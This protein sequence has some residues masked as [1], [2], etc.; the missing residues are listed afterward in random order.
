M[1]EIPA[2]PPAGK[3]VKWYYRT[4]SVLTA[5]VLFGPLAYPLLWKSPKYNLT[6]KIIL[7][8]IFTA[9]TVYMI[10]ATWHIYALL[11][12]TFRQAGLI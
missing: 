3:T 8:V 7:T 9:A 10:I 4:P 12:R 5:L 2:I 6:W 1:T 11:F